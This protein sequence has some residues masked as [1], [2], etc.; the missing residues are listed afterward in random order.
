V[1]DRLHPALHDTQRTLNNTVGRCLFCLAALLCGLSASSA[2]RAAPATVTITDVQRQLSG[3]AE[4]ASVR[5]ALRRAIDE[6][7][8]RD[9][10]T[11]HLAPLAAAAPS[12]SK[13]LLQTLF[14]PNDLCR[15]LPESERRALFDS[16]RWRFQM[17]T[18]WRISAIDWTCC[19]GAACEHPD[20]ASC[21]AEGHAFMSQLRQGLPDTVTDP[22]F[23]ALFDAMRP[24]EP[25]LRFERYTFFHEPGDA[26]GSAHPRLRRAA[27]PITTAVA[28]AQAGAILGPIATRQGH[29][30]LRL[31]GSRPSVHYTWDDPRTQAALRTELCPARVAK[32]RRQYL[33]DLRHQLPIVVDFAG[34][35]AT[36]GIKLTPERPQ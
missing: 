6:A 5:E 2:V 24:Q 3:P 23:G 10:A 13:T 22:E 9:E 26:T 15:R 35:E 19:S 14:S 34:I 32:A 17:P 29:A 4:D 21:R 7:L 16:A 33:S 31:R 18:A 8:L 28:G 27:S 25:H 12:A 20:V 11:R 1:S 36:W 30:L